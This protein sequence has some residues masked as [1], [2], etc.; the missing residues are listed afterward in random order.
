MND[1]LSNDLFMLGLMNTKE[2]QV[3]PEWVL[4]ENLH[5]CEAFY[6]MMYPE[7]RKTSR[8]RKGMLSFLQ[9][10]KSKDS[11]VEQIMVD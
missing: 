11:N 1:L 5:Q 7:K 6:Q 3:Y 4:A 9:R 2:M 10:K 8:K